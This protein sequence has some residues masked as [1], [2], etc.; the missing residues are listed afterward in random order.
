MRFL[1][2]LYTFLTLLAQPI[3]LIKRAPASSSLEPG[4]WT[5]PTTGDTV[6]H[7]D[8]LRAFKEKEGTGN[9]W[10]P[11]GNHD[12]FFVIDPKAPGERQFLWER[13]VGTGKA[14]GSMRIIVTL[15]ASKKNPQFRGVLGH[16]KGDPFGFGRTRFKPD[17]PAL[18]EISSPVDRA[19]QQAALTARDK[20]EQDAKKARQEALEAK[21][22]ETAAKK[23]GGRGTS[24][25][26]EDGLKGPAP[27]SQSNDGSNDILGLRPAE[28]GGAAPD[29]LANIGDLPSQSSNI[30][31]G[32]HANEQ[33]DAAPLGTDAEH[34]SG[35]GEHGSVTEVEGHGGAGQVPHEFI[36]TAHG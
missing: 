13:R 25:R 5:N 28:Q 26:T 11:F 4:V 16:P 21:A 24:G 15:S 34:I 6:T 8:V 12:N 36:P 9:D 1:I 7:E 18:P 35:G 29:P 33:Q 2:F 20:A 10:K 17:N 14:R 23:K 30:D 22:R 32:F 31:G 27:E 19:Q 3:E